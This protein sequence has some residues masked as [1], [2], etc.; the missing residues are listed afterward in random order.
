MRSRLS[1]GSAPSAILTAT[2]LRRELGGQVVLGGISVS[3]GPGDRV[4][5]V[6]PNGVGKSTL[7]RTLA[8]IECPDGGRVEVSPPWASV[9]YLAQDRERPP[10]IDVEGYLRS[11]SGLAKAEAA[12]VAASGALASGDMSTDAQEGYG[13]ALE[14]FGQLDPTGF[15]VRAAR[16]LAD[17][18]AG[19]ELLGAPVASLSGG[20]LARV[21]L[22]ALM[23]SR[24][25]ITLLDEPTNDLDFDGLDRL[26]QMVT[27]LE[28]GAMVVSHDRA[29]LARTV[30]SV[31]ELDIRERTATFY[32][33]GWEAYLREKEALARHR[34]TAYHNYRQTREE[35][36]GRAQR[37]RQ[38]A[39][40]GVSRERRHPRDND[41]AQRAFRV[42][43]TEHLAA[44]ARR[45]TKALERLEEVDKPWED[46][47]LR[48][49]LKVA[50]RAGAMVA[51]LSQAVVE[52]GPFRLGPWTWS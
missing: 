37:E 5:V 51:S 1:A 7:L 13:R 17:L 12:L 31:L 50:P 38:W 34:A 4:G 10:G 41:K 16:A 9:G 39:T 27:G 21:G 28:G 42:N 24:F 25:D 26:E 14:R 47:Q 23:L 45:T 2:G 15:G 20:E 40:V 3:V 22:A 19:A 49:S 52:K 6:G 8:G 18:G 35:L 30:N 36:G 48:Y 33:G 11:H 46:W 32:D 29:F 43:R 44:R